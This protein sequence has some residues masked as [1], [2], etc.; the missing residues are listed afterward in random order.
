MDS[1]SNGDK[2]ASDAAR[3]CAKLRTYADKTRT[4]MTEETKQKFTSK[5]RRGLNWVHTQS[6]AQFDSLRNSAAGGRVPGFSA[7]DLADIEA[8]LVWI[9]QNKEAKAE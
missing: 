8:A 1:Q 5:V 2:T 9:E 4:D 3:R 7:G 6:R